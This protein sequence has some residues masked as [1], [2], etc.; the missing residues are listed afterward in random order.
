MLGSGTSITNTIDTAA[1][2][3]IHSPERASRASNPS[4]FFFAVIG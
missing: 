3:M 4:C 1:T 2:G